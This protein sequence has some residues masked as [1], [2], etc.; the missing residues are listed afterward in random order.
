[1]NWL[2]PVAGIGGAGLGALGAWLWQRARH[3]AQTADL[4][5]ETARLGTR[6]EERTQRL[7]DLESEAEQIPQLVAARAGLQAELDAERRGAGERKV[8]LK[9]GEAALRAAA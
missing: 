9:E 8:L 7:T 2:I 4:T 1:M 6:L 5:Q 3:L